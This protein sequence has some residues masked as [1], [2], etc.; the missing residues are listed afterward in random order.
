MSS[1]SLT[2]WDVLGRLD[3]S[4]LSLVLGLLLFFVFIATV[5]ISTLIARTVYAFHR[6]RLEDALKRD[7][8]ERGFSVEEITQ[9][10]AATGG[11][12]RVSGDRLGPTAMNVRDPGVER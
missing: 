3:G 12:P 7:L 9:I 1:E 2:M 4:D 5:V 11:G 10:V 6:S 8:V